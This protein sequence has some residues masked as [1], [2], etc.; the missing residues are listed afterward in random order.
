MTAALG[1]LTSMENTDKGKPLGLKV[2]NIF[3]LHRER[4]GDGSV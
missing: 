2:V 1:I 3:L 4:P